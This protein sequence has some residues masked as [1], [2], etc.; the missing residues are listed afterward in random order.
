VAAAA[1]DL[2]LGVGHGGLDGGANG[3][4]DGAL[5]IGRMRGHERFRGVAGA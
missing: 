1:G 4:D 3:V 2:R 5:K